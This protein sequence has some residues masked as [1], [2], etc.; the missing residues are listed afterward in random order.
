MSSIRSWATPLTIG[1]F[2]LSAVTG[3][4]MFFHLD[5]GLNKV[6]HE[7]LSWALVGGVA[8][9]VSANWRAFST[10]LKKPRALS[11]IGAFALALFVSFFSLG[12]GEGSSPVAAVMAGMGA[13]PVER[14]IALT[15]E[16]QAAGLARLNA[17]GIKATAGQTIGELSGGDRGRQASILKVIFS[18]G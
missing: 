1:A 6:V 13:A 16:D 4:L 10:Y 8:L 12:G 18:E 15:G 14:V 17:A 11:I 9:H 3:V 2:G 5:S 7:W